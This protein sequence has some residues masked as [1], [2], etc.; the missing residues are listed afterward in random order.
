[1][2]SENKDVDSVLLR[3]KN[4]LVVVVV[5]GRGGRWQMVMLGGGG[6]GRTDSLTQGIFCSYDL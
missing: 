2:E 6:G 5:G 3:G 4:S 1:M